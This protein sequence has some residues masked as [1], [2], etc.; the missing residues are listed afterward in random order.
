MVAPSRLRY[1]G[2]C[3]M[4]PI[5]ILWVTWV[6]LGPAPA[7]ADPLSR[8]RA[9]LLAKRHE[10]AVQLAKAAVA[11]APAQAAYLWAVAL[12]AL[13]R[14]GEAAARFEEAARAATN[15]SRLRSRALYGAAL[16]HLAARDF[17]ACAR[18]W[19]AYLAFARPLPAEARFV[20]VA[21][22]ELARCAEIA[23]P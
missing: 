5:L 15:D 10:R 1:T 4:R 2:S 6:A 9:A 13:G 20:P 14:S 12:R 19:K 18:A 11:R 8:A 16:A 21:E 17:R 23:G 7:G 3:G 22:R